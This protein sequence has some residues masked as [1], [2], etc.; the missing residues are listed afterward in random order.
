MCQCLPSGPKCCPWGLPEWTGEHPSSTLSHIYDTHLRSD[1]GH[2][3]CCVAV[4]H[5]H[6]VLAGGTHSLAWV[7]CSVNR[8]LVTSGAGSSERLASSFSCTA[9]HVAWICSLTDCVLHRA[10]AGQDLPVNPH[11]HHLWTIETSKITMTLC[12]QW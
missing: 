11:V 12:V 7:S 4:H 6:G 5:I 9:Q 2:V 10:T 1:C 8:T 3:I